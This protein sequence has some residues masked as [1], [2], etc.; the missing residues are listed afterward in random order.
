[1]VQGP[2]EP[3]GPS[4]QVSFTCYWHPEVET[5]LSCSRCEKRI[6]AQCMVQAP[7]GIRCRECGKA[8]PMPTYDVRPANYTVGIGVALA[9]LVFGTPLWVVLDNVLLVFGAYG[10]VSGLLAV[11][12]GYASGQLVSLSVNRKRNSLLALTAGA[13]VIIAYLVSRLF[14]PFP[15]G[16]WDV[17]FVGIGTYLAWQ[18][19]RP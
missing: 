3:A 6:C 2:F 7:V 17:M 5:G 12:F 8:Q 14:S 19:L 10:S 16:L 11:A 15:F 1:M 18:S 13:V 4:D 9:L